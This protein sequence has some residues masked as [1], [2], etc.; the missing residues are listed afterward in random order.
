MFFSNSLMKK[1][2]DMAA[3][4]ILC[5]FGAISYG[6]LLLFPFEGLHIY[7]ANFLL[8]TCAGGWFNVWQLILEMRV[9]P[10]NV[11][12]VSLLARTISCAA[13]LASPSISIL[14]APLPYI[15]LGGSGLIGFIASRFLP[16]A[17]LHLTVFAKDCQIMSQQERSTLIRSYYGSKQLINLH[18]MSFIL[19]Q[20]ERNLNTAKL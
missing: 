16:P 17:G 1:L 5:L 18:S 4:N 20:T 11:G 19:S 6:I 3:F 12:S 8:V 13:A 9:P 10:K 15:I 14:P 7:I 2:S